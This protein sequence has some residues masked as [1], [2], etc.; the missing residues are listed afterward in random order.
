MSVSGPAGWT[1]LRAA[2]G[3][4]SGPWPARD[5]RAKVRRAGG[6]TVGVAEPTDIAVSSTGALAVWRVVRCPGSGLAAGTTRTAWLGGAS[7]CRCPG[8][9]RASYWAAPRF[10]DSR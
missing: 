4:V 7:R 1:L 8:S 5:I 10:P 9:T 2:G 6:V 3:V